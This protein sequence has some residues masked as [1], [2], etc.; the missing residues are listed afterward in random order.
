MVYIEDVKLISEDETEMD[1]KNLR[2]VLH[3]LLKQ[4]HITKLEFVNLFN[5]VEYHRCNKK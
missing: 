5:C 2:D 1:Y 4:N 3:I